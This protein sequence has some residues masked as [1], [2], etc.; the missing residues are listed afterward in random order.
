[1]RP[2]H[3]FKAKEGSSNCIAC[4]AASVGS[5]LLCFT[6][7]L[8]KMKRL[9]L[10]VPAIVLAGFLL[11]SFVKNEKETEEKATG[12][13]KPATGA[14]LRDKPLTDRSAK[15][16][17]AKVKWDGPGR[18]NIV[19]KSDDGG[20]TWQDVSEGLPVIEQPVIFYAGESD[21]YLNVKNVMYHSASGLKTPV[22]EK[23]NAPDLKKE[24]SWPSTSIAFNRSGAM[25]YGYGGQ[26]YQKIPASQTWLPVHTNFKRNSLRTVFETSGGTLFFG[27]DHGLYK[28]DDKGKNWK[29]VQKGQVYDVVESEGVLVASGKKGIMHSTDNGEHWQSLFSDGGVGIAVEPIKGGFAAISYNTATKSRKIRISPNRGKTWQSVD[30]GLPPSSFISSIKQ[31]D[32]YLICGHPDGIFRSSDMGKTWSRV[33]TGVDEHVFRIYVSGKVLYAVAGRPGC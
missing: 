10:I 13:A 16:S 25:A 4:P 8:K 24:R 32:N 11:I 1:V 18:A 29:Q 28:S 9:F 15:A 21:L 30:D 27:Y 2:D 5:L 6:L 31:M 33:Y 23:E 26:I 12:E 3:W 19:L 17:L 20:K 14:T 7:N 22:W